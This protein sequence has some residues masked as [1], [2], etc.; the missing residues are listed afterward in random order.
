M[1]RA[2]RQGNSLPPVYTDG[3]NWLSGTHRVAASEIRAQLDG[4]HPYED[5]DIRDM[6][7]W[8]NSLT[9]TELQEVWQMDSEDLCDLFDTSSSV[10]DFRATLHNKY[11]WLE[12]EE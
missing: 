3:G 11:P 6:G 2:L 7:G 1:I 12:G 10:N 5:L 9:E 8:L 4:T